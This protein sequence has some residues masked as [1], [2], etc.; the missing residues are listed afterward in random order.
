[1]DRAPGEGEQSSG[2]QPQ[3]PKREY[4]GEVARTESQNFGL[5]QVESLAS[6]KARQ[7]QAQEEMEAWQ[8]TQAAARAAGLDEPSPDEAALEQAEQAG[9]ERRR[10]ELRLP[11]DATVD[12]VSDADAD[13]SWRDALHQNIAN[14]RAKSATQS[15]APEPAPV[16]PSAPILKPYQPKTQPPDKPEIDRGNVEA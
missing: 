4:S 3:A 8:R 14:L 10:E 5:E 1:M 7:K 12:E 13:A 11:L 15:P 16:D 6:R 9:L 2:D